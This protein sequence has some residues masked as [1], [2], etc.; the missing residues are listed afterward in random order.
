[1]YI[2]AEQELLTFYNRYPTHSPM[3]ELEITQYVKGNEEKGKMSWK[4]P[5]SRTFQ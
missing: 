4:I 5:L 2:V 3:T 1:M